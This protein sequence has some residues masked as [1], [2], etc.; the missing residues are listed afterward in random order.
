MSDIATKITVVGGSQSESERTIVAAG[1]SALILGAFAG[2]FTNDVVTA[3]DVDGAH[4]FCIRVPQ[5]ITEEFTVP[6][7]ADNGMIIESG[8]SS[9][10]TIV[11]VMWRP[12]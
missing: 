9:A 12:I 7:I 8:G 3:V 5:A 11:T 6:F 2:S 10:S 1:E 4:L